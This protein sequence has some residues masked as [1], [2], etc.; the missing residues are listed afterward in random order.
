[1]KSLPVDG[2]SGSFP[3]NRCL[4]LLPASP[5][6]AFTLIELLVVIALVALLAGIASHAWQSAQ[7]SARAAVAMQ[8]L[9][10]IGTG[11]SHY[12]GDHHDRLP[13]P[14]WPGQVPELDPQR[15]GRLVREL[16]P[17]LGI[18]TPAT[19]EVVPLFVPP[20]FASAMPQK[21][22]AQS[23]AFVLNML[24]PIENE[25]VAPWGNLAIPPAT[26]PHRLGAMP[27]HIWALSDADQLHPRVRNAAWKINTPPEPVHGRDRIALYFGGAV[28]R[29]PHEDLEAP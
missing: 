7:R 18:A 6:A 24:V 17:Y 9:K 14:L 3:R 23:R 11:I 1:M 5:R 2:A 20:A 22:I 19:P 28:A 25:I 13:G 16:A 27:G 12:A 8:N 4:R 10:Q 15:E 29:I 21:S 26:G